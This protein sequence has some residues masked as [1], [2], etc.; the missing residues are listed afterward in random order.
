MLV[1]LLVTTVSP[2]KTVEPIEL[3]LR[4]DSRGKRTTLVKG[5]D[6]RTVED[7]LASGGCAYPF[8]TENYIQIWW[9]MKTKVRAT[10]SQRCVM[11]LSFP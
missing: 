1:H 6:P 4:A 7:P 5:S 9:C 2:A 8:P 11:S 3:P 10:V